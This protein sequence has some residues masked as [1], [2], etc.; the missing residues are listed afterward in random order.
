[1]GS[2][3]P[4]LIEEDVPV[5]DPQLLNLACQGGITP[6]HP[7]S[8]QETQVVLGLPQKFICCFSP[9]LFKNVA[10]SYRFM[11]KITLNTL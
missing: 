5:Q 2:H 3:C 8:S 9:T 4:P 10:N 6:C 11:L 1:M 7:P